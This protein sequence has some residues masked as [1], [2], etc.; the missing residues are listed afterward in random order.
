MNY[1]NM[2]AAAL[3]CVTCCHAWA[4]NKCT[5][6]DGKLAFQDAPCSNSSSKSEA[7]IVRPA[8]GDGSA[9]PLTSPDTASAPVKGK[10]EAQRLEGIVAESQRNRR[11]QEFEVR[12]IPE[13][14]V[15]IDRQRKQ[16]DQDLKALQDKKKSANNNL[17][18][19]TWEAS[20]SSEMSAVAIRCDTKNRE[21]R[22]EFDS[23]K[24]ECR[25][26]SAS[27]NHDGIS[28]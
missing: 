17:A 11:K 8:S 6:P 23:L 13:A 9:P 4:V 27:T 7:L 1:P 21:L 19:A 26:L 20:I 24:Q 28:R 10:T 18:G 16:C 2:I 22:E 12:V 3:L 14:R 5:G 25:A 15:A